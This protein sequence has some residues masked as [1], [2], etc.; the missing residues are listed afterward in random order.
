VY[1]FLV[2]VLAWPPTDPSY[3]FGV[4]LT[5]RIVRQGIPDQA[6]IRYRS[7]EGF[8][9]ETLDNDL[10][11]FV[12]EIVPNDYATL[13]VPKGIVA[14]IEQIVPSINA[15]FPMD[16]ILPHLDTVANTVRFASEIALAEIIESRTTDPAHTQRR[17][18]FR[19][20]LELFP[21]SESTIIGMSAVANAAFLDGD[22]AA[23]ADWLRRARAKVQAVDFDP[24]KK[25]QTLAQIDQMLRR[26]AQ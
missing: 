24:A 12:R 8:A 25:E 11:K 3:V 6:T 19:R 26:V 20:I 1:A 17:R 2:P 7:S 10:T 23:S 4:R 15:Q 5:D 14:P 13:F 21:E 22:S 9:N 18:L 16:V